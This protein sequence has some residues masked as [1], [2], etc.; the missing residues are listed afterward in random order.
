MQGLKILRLDLASGKQVQVASGYEPYQNRAGQLV[1]RDSGVIMADLGN[2]PREV[3]SCWLCRFP[4]LSPDGAWVAWNDQLSNGSGFGTLVANVATGTTVYEIA[5]Y[6]R[7]RSAWSEDGYL[8]VAGGSTQGKEGIAALDLA[9]GNLVLVTA[10]IREPSSPAI[11]P[12]GKWVAAHSGVDDQVWLAPVGGKDAK[13][14]TKS[15]LGSTFPFFSPGGEFL[16]LTYGTQSAPELRVIAADSK[17]PVDLDHEEG[18]SL[19]AG[20][21]AVWADGPFTWR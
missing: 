14:L 12:D 13:P 10:A 16:L 1:W 3:V 20:G 11:S 8:V 7:G 17:E 4:T 5:D 15:V 6:D 2:G 18:L 9:S 19:Q 21:T